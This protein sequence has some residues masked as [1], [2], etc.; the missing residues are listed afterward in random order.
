M[1]ASGQ[2]QP[3]DPLPGMQYELYDWKWAG[4]DVRAYRGE[5][6]DPEFLLPGQPMPALTAAEQQLGFVVFT[7]PWMEL[8][9]PISVPRREQITDR[10]QL[11]A[12]PGEFEPLTCLV[13]PQRDL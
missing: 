9:F 4:Q 2:G 11:A 5:G 7:T 3:A 10:L 1:V 6:E 8:T 13:R 12:A